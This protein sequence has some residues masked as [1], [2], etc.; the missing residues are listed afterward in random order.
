M[1]YIYG[2]DGQIYHIHSSQTNFESIKNGDIVTVFISMEEKA[3][4]WYINSKYAGT[5]YLKGM[6]YH[7]KLR[8]FILMITPND[9]MEILP[10]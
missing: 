2:K 6:D 4:I 1:Y 8:P 3:I 9:Q 10:S 5:Y 7:E